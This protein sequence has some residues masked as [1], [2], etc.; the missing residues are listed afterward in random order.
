MTGLRAH[1]RPKQEE[2]WVAKA[3]PRAAPCW[4]RYRA[5]LR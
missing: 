2:E 1:R 3:G 5:L 4:S